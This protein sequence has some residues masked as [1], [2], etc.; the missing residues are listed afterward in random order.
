MTTSGK[1]QAWH[2]KAADFASVALRPVS[3]VNFT[4]SI[5]TMLHAIARIHGSRLACAHA[6][7]LIAPSS[8]VAKSSRLNPILASAG[9]AQK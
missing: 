4:T 6:S 3:A 1:A 2:Q 8:L 9:Y 5:L 7:D